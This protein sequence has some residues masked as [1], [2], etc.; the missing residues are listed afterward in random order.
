[1][2]AE[3]DNVSLTIRQLRRGIIW[4]PVAAGRHM[5]K[6]KLRGH[7]PTDAILADYEA[8]IQ[9]VLE[10]EDASIYV[11]LTDESP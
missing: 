1:M 10:A 3:Q 2:T 11:Y 9:H 4:K 7:L 5:L 8:I 6:R